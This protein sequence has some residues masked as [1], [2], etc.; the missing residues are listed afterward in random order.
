MKGAL[1]KAVE[2][3]SRFLKRA[4]KKIHEASI[5]YGLPASLS[6]RT[7]KKEAWFDSLAVED[8]DSLDGELI[9]VWWQNNAINCFRALSRIDLIEESGTMH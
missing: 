3:G 4:P 9:L 6:R 2:R 8:R 5:F 1:K 7:L